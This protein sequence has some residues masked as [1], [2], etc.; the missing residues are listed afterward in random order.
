[1]KTHIVAEMIETQHQAE[2]LMDLGVEFGQ[3]YYFGKPEDRMAPLAP[4]RGRSRI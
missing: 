4:R 1:M 3:G 2:T